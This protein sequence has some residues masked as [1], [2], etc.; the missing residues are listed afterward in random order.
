MNEQLEGWCTDHFKRHEARWMSV[1]TPTHLVRDGGVESRDDPPDEPWLQQPEPI[2]PVGRPISTL[3]A[4]D[5]QAQ[6]F[7]SRRALDAAQTAT[8]WTHQP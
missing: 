5:A 4:D 6:S 8:I 7:G 1:G 2:I 3:R